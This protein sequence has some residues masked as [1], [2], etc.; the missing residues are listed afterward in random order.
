MP[1][2]SANKVKDGKIGRPSAKQALQMR[3][4]VIQNASSSF[5]SNSESKI[6]CWI[7]NE[8]NTV[9]K[10]YSSVHDLRREHAGSSQEYKKQ[11]DCDRDNNS[12]EDV[13]WFHTSADNTDGI[14]VLVSIFGIRREHTI[15]IGRERWKCEYVCGK[16][17]SQDHLKIAVSELRF[18]H[19]DDKPQDAIPPV[20]A[21]QAASSADDL[22]LEAVPLHL[23]LLPDLGVLVSIGSPGRHD[24]LLR[25]ARVQLLNRRS[26]LY[27]ELRRAAAAPPDAACGAEAAGRRA[28]G[29]GALA[30]VLLD[31]VMDGIFPVLDVF[32][33]AVEGVQ[34]LNKRRCGGGMPMTGG[35][36]GRSEPRRWSCG[37]W[38]C[39][40]R[41][42]GVRI[43]EHAEREG[44][45]R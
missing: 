12:L 17:S 2:K 11:S 42:G 40:G 13:R 39:R 6:E 36:R 33:D 34:L 3:Q 14:E 32:G 30:V 19:S 37:C 8:M 15:D 16:T 5:L 45:E 22:A 38:T 4:V 18:L 1:Q 31:A 24:A 23:F 28:A 21:R 7:F 26:V 44:G 20:S 9:F 27:R 43:R 35:R 41:G 10:T 29:C 25:A